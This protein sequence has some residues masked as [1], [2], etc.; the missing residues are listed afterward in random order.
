M[1]FSTCRRGRSR[2][3]RPGVYAMER[4]TLLTLYPL[5]T[6][7]DEIYEEISNNSQIL[8]TNSPA[9]TDSS[10]SNTTQVYIGYDN[11]PATEVTSSSY[12]FIDRSSGNT[13][14]I[15]EIETQ[16][17]VTYLDSNNQTVTDFEDT[18][19]TRVII[20]TEDDGSTHYQYIYSEDSNHFSDQPQDSV[21]AERWF[22][23]DTNYTLTQ[24]FTIAGDQY[25]DAT[26]TLT[27]HGFNEEG[28]RNQLNYNNQVYQDSSYGDTQGS[29]TLV[30]AGVPGE[31]SATSWQM[32]FDGYDSESDTEQRG[33]DATLDFNSFQFGDRNHL[34]ISASGYGSFDDS[35]A[36]SYVLHA[37]GGTDQIMHTHVY[38]ASSDGS[39]LIDYQSDSQM[40][41][42]YVFDDN[43]GTYN[44]DGGGFEYQQML[45]TITTPSDIISFS[46][47]DPY[48]EINPDDTYNNWQIHAGIAEP[49]YTT[50]LIA[51]TAILND[52][53]VPYPRYKHLPA[54]VY[55]MTT[56][57]QPTDAAQAYYNQLVDD[58]NSGNSDWPI[59]NGIPTT[60][61]PTFGD[62][63][64]V[65]TMTWTQT[66]VV[67]FYARQDPW[68]KYFT[69]PVVSQI[70][71]SPDSGIDLTY[72]WAG[73]GIDQLTGP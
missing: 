72:Y 11:L 41:S 21:N 49:M 7:P 16:T 20:T 34:T 40:S 36:T 69:G 58:F 38:G 62:P 29:W 31:P 42:S 68:P 9:G 46:G 43:N 63:D 64:F 35:P 48:S 4:R 18:L 6:L 37:D 73:L 3:F 66:S 59:A 1:R 30:A 32:S 15:E 51:P 52:G 13:S 67:P 27:G 28:A 57:D 8:N 55:P 19:D 45:G 50:G 12:T 24:D 70:D 17:D 23:Q 65:D 39:I 60:G 5:A 25:E 56:Y 61:L 10:S 14:D 44:L 47:R 2:R 33:S 71:P 26:F 22:N 53:P 54:A